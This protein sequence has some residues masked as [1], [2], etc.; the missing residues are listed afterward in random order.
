[1]FNFDFVYDFL[2]LFLLW[3]MFY[4]GSL[5]SRGKG[6][7]RYCS[8]III[9][10]TL[11]E[12]VRY[13]R[14]VDYM[15]YIDVYNYNLEDDQV[16]FTSLN[17]FLKYLGVSAEMSFMVYAFSFIVG[18]LLMMKPMRKYAIYVFPLF[19]MSIIS[20]HEAFI[21]QMLAM[22]FVFIYTVKLY[23]FISCISVK[24]INK[25]DILTLIFWGVIACSIHSIAIV[26]IFVIT[27]V[28]LCIKKPFPWQITIPLLILGKFVISKSFDWSS[29]GGFLSFLGS[30]NDKF[31]SYTE[32]SDRWFSDTAMQEGFTRNVT[33]QFL[34]TFGCCAILYL[35]D[36]MFN[37]IKKEE[38]NA[39]GF[40]EFRT[41]TC[42][43]PYYIS[44]FNVFVIG[45]LIFETFS[46]LEIVRR[47]AY[48]WNFFWF[49][50]MSLILYY[51]NSKLFNAFDR[52]LM[53]GFTFW[54]WEYIRF[55]FVWSD[56]PLFIWDIYI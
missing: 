18:A 51:W 22:S 56:T 25:K 48:C 43:L 4:E 12:G 1:M 5:V 8:W 11:I 50:P 36:K 49:A 34:E 9:A 28:M 27:L 29:L 14:G 45:M 38:E 30:T 23:D 44:L 21:R 40:K 42:K 3:V 26:G 33:I 15:H 35:S 53:L 16:L 7:W 13:G 24:K 37:K 32:N 17:N 2:N 19:L 10:F 55:L 31:S 47:V 6:Y 46:T 39:Y 20:N 41:E 52:I 54:L